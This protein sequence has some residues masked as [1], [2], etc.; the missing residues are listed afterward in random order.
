MGISNTCLTKTLRSAAIVCA[1]A[2]V[3]VVNEFA[4]RISFD[5]AILSMEACARLCASTQLDV[6]TSP[7]FCHIN[8]LDCL[9]CAARMV[10]SAPRPSPNGHLRLNQTGINHN[11]W[12]ATGVRTADCTPK[13]FTRPPV[14]SGVPDSY[15]AYT[16]SV[17]TE[18]IV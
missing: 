16:H 17:H 4:N 5:Y 2:F 14:P 3:F 9:I 10:W 8:W 1:C 18:H 12:Q 6:N 11:E 7:M 13:S 15:F